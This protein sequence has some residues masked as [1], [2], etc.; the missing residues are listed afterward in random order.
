VQRGEIDSDCN[1]YVAS[2]F[3]RLLQ[4]LFLLPFPHLSPFA[5]LLAS[6][7]PLSDEALESAAFDRNRQWQAFVPL[8]N[9][10]TYVFPGR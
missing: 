2:F 5:V 3:L 7:Y 10:E 9:A 4:L 1:W 6:S 8:G